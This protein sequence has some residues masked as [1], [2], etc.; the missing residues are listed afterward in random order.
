M[1]PAG[2]MTATLSNVLRV[3]QAP[4]AQNCILLLVVWP[5]RAPASN[6]AVR[7]LGHSYAFGPSWTPAW[8]D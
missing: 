8:N 1:N 4:V 7:Y 5:C 2:N 3:V 6:G